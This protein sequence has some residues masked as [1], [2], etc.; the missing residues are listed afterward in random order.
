[1]NIGNCAV[2]N[3]GAGLKEIERRGDELADFVPVI[4]STQNWPVREDE[5]RREQDVNEKVRL[6]ANRAPRNG[7]RAAALLNDARGVSGAGVEPDL[8]EGGFVLSHVVLQN[9]EEGLGLLRAHVDALEVGDADVIGSGR[10]DLAEKQ[11][12]V[13]EIHPNLDAVGVTFSVVGGLVENDSR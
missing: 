10:V 7:H 8:S 6:R 5:E 4:G 9:A 11:E 13:P 3:P 12:E 2:G 1:M